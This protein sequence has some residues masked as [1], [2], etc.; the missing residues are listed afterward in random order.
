[1]RRY[2]DADR[3]S[4]RFDMM[5]DAGGVLAPITKAVREMVKKIIKTEPTVDVQSTD[6]EPVKGWISVRDRLPPYG[7]RVFVVN[8]AYEAKHGYNKYNVGV[9]VRDPNLDFTFWGFKTTYWMPLP[10]PPKSFKFGGE[11]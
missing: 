10:E 4:E 9:T 8:E 5:C 1:M 2:I 11:K 6:V 7:E 3:F